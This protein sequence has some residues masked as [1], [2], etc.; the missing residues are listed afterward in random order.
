MKEKRLK[1]IAQI[2]LIPVIDFM[3]A[4]LVF[5]LVAYSKN[6]LDFFS[7]K[8]EVPGSSTAEKVSK[9]KQTLNLNINKDGEISIDD[10]R[11]DSQKLSKIIADRKKTG[12]D[13]VNIKGDSQA[14]YE[15]IIFTI[16]QVKE[17][18]IHKITLLTRKLP[19]PEKK[20]G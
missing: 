1:P 18:G 4:L 7:Q 5:F 14:P 15:R 16:D 2:I 19:K 6:S 10:E 8:I 20:E 12:I 3:M 9:D 11:I 17:A 13:K